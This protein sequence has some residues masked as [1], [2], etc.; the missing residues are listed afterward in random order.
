MVQGF[1]KPDQKARA[2][3]FSFLSVFCSCTLPVYELVPRLSMR[4]QSSNFCSSC[5]LALLFYF[6]HVASLA[7]KPLMLLI[8]VGLLVLN[9]NWLLISG[10]NQWHLIVVRLNRWHLIVRSCRVEVVARAV[11]MVGLSRNRVHIMIFLIIT[12][13]N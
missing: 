4:L 8:R 12:T 1:S 3:P 2:S 13:K 5:V 11:W 6:L 10:L 9:D 7:S